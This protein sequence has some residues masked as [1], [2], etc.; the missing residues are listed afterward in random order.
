M[1][2]RILVELEIETSYDVNNDT[3]HGVQ[4]DIH[5]ALG[6]AIAFHDLEYI[7]AINKVQIR[8]IL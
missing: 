4:S 1:K 2:K 6:Y 8:M 3:F 5:A 7:D